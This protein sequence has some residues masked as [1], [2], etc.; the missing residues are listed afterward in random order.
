SCEDAVSELSG[1]RRQQEALEREISALRAGPGQ[2]PA[3]TSAP[4]V[5]PAPPPQP[6]PSAEPVAKT[7]GAVA[8]SAKR[9]ARGDATVGP[10][11]V[12]H[13]EENKA[14][15][16]A[17]RAVVM[18]LPDSRYLNAL[19]AT[20]ADAPGSR[21]LLVN[22]LSRAHDPVAAIASFIA[23]DT[24]QRS[25][26]AYCADG[27][28]GFSFG[29]ADFFTQPVDADACIAG[30]LES[31]GPIHR[32]F[33]ASENFSVVVALRNVLSRMQASVSSAPDLR[34]VLELMPMVE[35]D[36]LLI[37]L[38]L[39]RGE[40]LRLVSHLRSDPK[41]RELPLGILLA[42]SGSAADMRQH[43]QRAARNLPMTAMHLAEILS[44]R[45]GL[46]FVANAPTSADQSAS[47][48]Q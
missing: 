28:N 5:S 1:Q 21:L 39:P 18:R 13:L 46:A 9:S 8:K 45:L 48:L 2:S 10:T 26:F 33:V 15:C 31:S 42:A 19:D 25:V 47:A 40:G 23:A 29:M 44:Q 22:L 36:L 16:D 24:Y 34:Q 43:A 30:L 32:L 3:P 11:T 4:A 17:A 20:A 38:G 6:P 27:T 12:I 41:T 35:P 7:R 14:L 37:D